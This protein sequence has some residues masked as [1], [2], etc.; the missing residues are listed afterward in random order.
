MLK[1]RRQAHFEAWY[2]DPDE[3]LPRFNPFR[4][5]RSRA[6][7]S[8]PA[9]P[10]LTRHHSLTDLR[11]SAVGQSVQVTPDQLQAR[12]VSAQNVS[13]LSPSTS[14]DDIEARA[15]KQITYRRRYF[16]SLFHRLIQTPADKAIREPD[17]PSHALGAANR[18]F[19]EL[20]R[21]RSAFVVSEI[22]PLNDPQGSVD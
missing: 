4:R 14:P 6:E 21:D 17:A 10:I 15:E 19:R 5:Y 3:D 7:A 22:G 18:E 12:L 2:G 9:S 13:S 16:S 11:T 8:K 1:Y 20:R